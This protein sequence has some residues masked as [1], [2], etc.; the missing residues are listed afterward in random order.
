M[1]APGQNMGEATF[2]VKL[3]RTPAKEPEGMGGGG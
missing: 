1:N 2:T 3:G